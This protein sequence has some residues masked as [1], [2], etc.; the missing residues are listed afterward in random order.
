[1]KVEDHA[2]LA[3]I[4]RLEIGRL[5]NIVVR[6]APGPG[7]IAD[8]GS[9]DLDHV[10]AQIGQ[11]HRREGSGEDAGEIEDVQTAKRIGHHE[12]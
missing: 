9:L 8:P 5:T 11:H 10:G 7:L 1:L 3:A 4:Y 6:R 2:S 12:V